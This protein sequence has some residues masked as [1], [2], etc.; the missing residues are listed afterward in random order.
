MLNSTNRQFFARA[1]CKKRAYEL[2][3]LEQKYNGEDGLSTYLNI[4]LAT[5][6]I[7]TLCP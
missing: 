1:E 3:E 6:F 2:M 4:W 5:I 7:D